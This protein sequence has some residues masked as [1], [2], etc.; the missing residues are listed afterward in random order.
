MAGGALPGVRPLGLRQ[1]CELLR[2]G[3]VQ[4]R[5]AG[6]LWRMAF[7]WGKELLPQGRCGQHLFFCRSPLYAASPAWTVSG[8]GGRSTSTGAC[9]EQQ[10][11]FRTSLDYAPEASSLGC[12]HCICLQGVDDG[13]EPTEEEVL[14][15]VYKA[16]E[17]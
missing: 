5:G 15:G 9:M 2:W 1:M 13:C 12:N 17:E 4:V 3:I 14:A 10:L 16:R 7:V 8:D 11:A 6:G